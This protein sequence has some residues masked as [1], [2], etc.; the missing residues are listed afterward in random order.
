MFLG[1]EGDVICSLVNREDFGGIFFMGIVD[2]WS[3]CLF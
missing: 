3:A 2:V 1:L